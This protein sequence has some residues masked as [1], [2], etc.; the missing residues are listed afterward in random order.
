[1]VRTFTPAFWAASSSV[2]DV[3]KAAMAFSCRGVKCSRTSCDITGY[4]PQVSDAK[5]QG[6]L[7][8]MLCHLGQL[9]SLLLDRY[10]LED[11]EQL[12]SARKHQ[13][14]SSGVRSR[15]SR[16]LRR[17][18]SAISRCARRWFSWWAIQAARF[19]RS[20]PF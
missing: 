17:C 5:E 20:K 4:P 10:I 9:L 6:I 18:E 14:A 8:A 1:M 13:A 16:A 11:L 15:S 3:I 2:L 12:V 7:W 19:S